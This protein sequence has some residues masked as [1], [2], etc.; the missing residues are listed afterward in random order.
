MQIFFRGLTAVQYCVVTK[1]SWLY[2]SEH[3]SVHLPKI[4]CSSVKHSQICPGQLRIYLVSLRLDSLPADMLPC[5]CFC[6]GKFQSPRIEHLSSPPLLSSQHF[7]FSCCFPVMFCFCFIPLLLQISTLITEVENTS[8]DPRLFPAM[9]F[10]G[11]SLAA[12]TNAVLYVV[13]MVLM[14]VPSSFSPVS[15]ATFPPVVA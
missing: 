15:V 2:S 9:F 12:S 7:E 4:S 11:I 14:S 8:G 10:P 1:L 6:S 13:I 5:C 3:Y